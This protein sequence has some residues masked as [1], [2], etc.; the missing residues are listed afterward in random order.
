MLAA[1][2]TLNVHNLHS[3]QR[4]E[5]TLC[6]WRMIKTPAFYIKQT[7]NFLLST[8]YVV[9]AIID[10]PRL[11][12][13][14]TNNYRGGQYCRQLL[15]IKLYSEWERRMSTLGD[16]NIIYIFKKK[17]KISIENWLPKN[18]G[19]RGK[20]CGYKWDLLLDVLFFPPAV[21]A[22]LQGPHCSESGS[23]NWGK[24]RWE[25]RKGGGFQEYSTLQSLSA[26]NTQPSSGITT[27]ISSM[28]F[29]SESKVVVHKYRIKYY[30]ILRRKNTTNSNY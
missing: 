1:L 5:L 12:K 19:R 2:F 30:M 16:G 21:N 3:T 10:T 14:L 27:Y 24:G 25:A 9:K 11:S 29:T 22:P 26:T 20:H 4:A 18:W 6:E 13:L 7:H 28:S 15:C 23:W 8:P 17:M